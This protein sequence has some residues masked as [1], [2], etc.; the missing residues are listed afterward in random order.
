MK[1]L[2]RILTI[3]F[4]ILA[5]LVLGTTNSVIG[6]GLLAGLAAISLF[7]A[8]KTARKEEDKEDSN[9]YNE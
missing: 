7:L 2:Y 8:F 6:A 5:L 1:N 4:I 3:V 9:F